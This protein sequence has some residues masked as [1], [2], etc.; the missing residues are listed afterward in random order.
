MAVLNS[1]IETVKNIYDLIDEDNRTVLHYL[2]L[3]KN[4]YVFNRLISTYPQ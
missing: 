4:F 3:N 1:S 2:A